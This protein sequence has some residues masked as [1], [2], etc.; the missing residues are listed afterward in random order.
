MID[1]IVRRVVGANFIADDDIR[2]DE[3][4]RIRARNVVGVL[5]ARKVDEAALRQELET[6]I[7]Y[8]DR[9]A[10]EEFTNGTDRDWFA[11]EQ[12]EAHLRVVIEEI[13]RAVA[14]SRAP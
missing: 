5:R 12:T 14:R 7:E 1:P 3:D 4:Y 10:L 8:W 11:N 6:L 13:L 2:T 9:S